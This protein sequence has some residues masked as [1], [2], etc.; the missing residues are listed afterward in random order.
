MDIRFLL[1]VFAGQLLALVISIVPAFAT[2]RVALVI[3]NAQY[4]ALETLSNPGR[5][6]KAV[7]TLLK[8]YGYNV[9]TYENLDFKAFS[10]A[11][12]AFRNEATGAVEAIVYYSGHGMEAI[13]SGQ[14]SNILAPVDAEIGCE[15]RTA[16]FTISL[17]EVLQV[18]SSVPN[19]IVILDACRSNP[20]RNCPT[21]SAAAGGSF[22]GLVPVSLP[23]QATLLAFSTDVG[24]LAYD[25]VP[26]THSPF[27]ESFLNHLTKSPTL[28]YREL[29]DATARDVRTK[30]ASQV[31]WIVA[32]SLFRVG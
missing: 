7:A 19:R 2:K 25:G 6:A 5:D 31:P 20:F 27:A 29:L 28:L 22:R 4:T 23:D 21:R 3:G 26:G 32:S 15:N 12:A 17:T 10:R 11:L 8:N 14:N 30:V 1:S 16:L 9:S 18:I 24:A 13:V